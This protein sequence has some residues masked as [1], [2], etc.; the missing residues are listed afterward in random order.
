MLR[1]SAF[2]LIELLVVVTIIVV[3]LAMLTPAIDKAIYQAELAVCGADLKAVGASVTLYAFDN[4]RYWPYRGAVTDRSATG[5]RTHVIKIKDPIL[6]SDDRAE[7]RPYLSLN[8]LLMDSLGPGK[9]DLENSHDDTHV[10]STYSLWFGW[11]YGRSPAGPESSMNKM[12]DRFSWTY[13]SGTSAQQVQFNVLAS[14]FDRID[15]GQNYNSHTDRGVA[16]QTPW[17]LQDHA[18]YGFGNT[19]LIKQTLAFWIGNV[20]TP[21]RG[22]I[23]MNTTFDDGSVRRNNRVRYDEYRFDG[24]MTWVPEYAEGANFPGT[25]NHLP[26]Q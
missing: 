18:A 20:N 17:V 19:G 25:Y 8:K 13:G 26:K 6:G 23:D 12:G 21:Q 7:L 1:I 3:L 24:P 15:P 4:K 22:P 16:L 5:L 11:G 2:T 14:D 10:Y 9:V